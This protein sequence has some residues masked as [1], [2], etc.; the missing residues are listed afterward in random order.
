MPKTTSRTKSNSRTNKRNPQ[1]KAEITKKWETDYQ[2]RIIQDTRRLL[3]SDYKRSTVIKFLAEHPWFFG[4][5]SLSKSWKRRDPE[6]VI[7]YEVFNGNK[8]SACG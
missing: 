6:I 8:R 7:R 2:I 1:S 5:R 4:Y 3:T